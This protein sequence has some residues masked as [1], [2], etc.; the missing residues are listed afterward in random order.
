MPLLLKNTIWIIIHSYR[1]LLITFLKTK[2]VQF[3]NMIHK[4]LTFLSETFGSQGNDKPPEC[5]MLIAK[6]RLPPPAG[7]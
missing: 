2:I 1:R 7:L 4:A 3:I 5:Q 6:Y